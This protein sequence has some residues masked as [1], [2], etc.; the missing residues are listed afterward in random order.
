VLIDSTKV[1][2]TK[3]A[4]FENIL[5]GSSTAAARLPLPDEVAKLLGES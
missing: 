4:S 1:D 3:L 5:Y 2:A